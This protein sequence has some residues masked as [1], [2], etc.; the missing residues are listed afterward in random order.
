M[1]M[2]VGSNSKPAS[3]TWSTPCDRKAGRPGRTNQARLRETPRQ[4]SCVP[5]S[6]PRILSGAV[7][8]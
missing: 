7:W 8:R 1:A 2:T 4:T 6:I 3:L 5:V